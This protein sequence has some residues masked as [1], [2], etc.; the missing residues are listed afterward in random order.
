MG[1]FPPF[2][3]ELNG[4]VLA[5][6]IPLR[7]HVEY[8]RP[9]LAPTPLHAHTKNAAEGMTVLGTELKV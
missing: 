4:Q 1:A 3:L 9:Y 6:S 2:S 7:L 5:A 8:R